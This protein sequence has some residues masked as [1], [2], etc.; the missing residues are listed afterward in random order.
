MGDGGKKRKETKIR[1]NIKNSNQKKVQKIK[2]RGMSKSELN[3]RN[4]KR[5]EK[6]K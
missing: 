3:I 4:N 1:D 2:G 6:N 5:R